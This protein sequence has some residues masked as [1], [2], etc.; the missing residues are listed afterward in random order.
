M[1]VNV[2]SNADPLTEFG[3]PVVP[4][5]FGSS[6]LRYSLDNQEGLKDADLF[7][8]DRDTGQLNLAAGTRLDRGSRS[9]FNF[10]VVATESGTNKSGRVAVRVNVQECS[11]GWCA[12]LSAEETATNAYGFDVNGP[13]A[14]G[15]LVPAQ[16]GIGGSV[17]TVT[18]LIHDQWTPFAPPVKFFVDPLPSGTPTPFYGYELRVGGNSLTFPTG[19]TDANNGWSWEDSE[20][21]SLQ[22]DAVADYEVTLDWIGPEFASDFVEYIFDVDDG[23]ATVTLPTATGGTG[24]LTYSFDTADA[25]WQTIEHMGLEDM[26][27]DGTLDRQYGQAIGMTTGKRYDVW[28]R[29]RGGTSDMD[30]VPGAPSDATVGGTPTAH[31]PEVG[32]I[33]PGS[34]KTR[35]QDAKPPCPEVW[36]FSQDENSLFSFA[37]FNVAPAHITD[38]DWDW[39]DI[40]WR[41]EPIYPYDAGCLWRVFQFSEGGY[42]AK[43]GQEY[44][45]YEKTRYWEFWAIAHDNHEGSTG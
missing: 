26:N 1:T 21:G 28:I 2:Y 39:D 29:A 36:V 33:V 30:A 40:Q 31:V 45:D 32:C 25:D 38:R 44:I 14:Q 19:L 15:K 8:I 13:D 11:A 7:Y 37:P 16:I 27:G 10:D 41:M 43:R 5:Y 42:L 9:S 17:Y 22:I 23:S 34:G 6:T 18:K 3:E 35:F 20:I 24:A 4:A 12:T